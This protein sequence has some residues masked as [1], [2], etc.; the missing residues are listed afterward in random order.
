M[1]NWLEFATLNEL[2][3]R[4]ALREFDLPAARFSA[5]ENTLLFLLSLRFEEFARFGWSQM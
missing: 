1:R 3:G 5:S 2:P 4:H